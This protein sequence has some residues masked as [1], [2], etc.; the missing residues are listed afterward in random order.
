MSH[1]LTKPITAFK[2][3]SYLNWWFNFYNINSF[4]FKKISLKK[5]NHEKS[6]IESKRIR[7]L[8]QLVQSKRVCKY[9][10]LFINR[11]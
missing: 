5:V 2:L 6:Y 10:K 9:L 1:C 8:T 7:N 4:I 3:K 11:V